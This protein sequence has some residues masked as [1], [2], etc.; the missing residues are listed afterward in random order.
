M[1]TNFILGSALLMVGVMAG[2][3][4]DPAPATDA[5]SDTGTI[6]DTGTATDTGASTD[7]GTATDTGSATDSGTST[8]AGSATDS[9]T[10]TDA[11]SATDSGTA[12]DAGSA[13]DSGTAT[14]AGSA[15]DSGTSA[16]AGSAFM[17]IHG[18]TEAMYVDR[19][20]TGERVVTFGGVVGSSYSPRC[21]IVSAGQ[22]VNFS[23][24]FTSHPLRTGVTPGSSATG[25][26]PNPIADTDSGSS[27]SFTFAAPGI[28]P[29]HCNFHQ[30]S[31][32]G[33]IL[34]R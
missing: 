18:C 17:E 21:M 22:M 7:T 15:T 23:G 5:G 12:T 16:D 29:Y 19:R 20:T 32:A 9:G 2:C 4:D 31:M 24:P 28:Y 6:V 34:V 3:S 10:A 25:T 14:D 8:D 27:V 13:T 33:V 11:G 1:R 30:P 26:T